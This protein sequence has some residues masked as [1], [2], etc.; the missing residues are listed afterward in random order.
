MKL[1]RPNQPIKFTPSGRPTRKS[2]A[3]LLSSY[4]RRYVV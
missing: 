4:S 3:L 2:E 1:L